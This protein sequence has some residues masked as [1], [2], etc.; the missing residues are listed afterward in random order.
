MR[1]TGFLTAAA[2]LVTGV[3]ALPG[4]AVAVPTGQGLVASVAPSK[5][6]KKQFSGISQSTVIS[7]TFDNYTTSQSPRTTTFTIPKDVKFTNGNIPTCPLSAIQ[8]KFDAQARASCPQSITGQGSVEVNGGPAAGGIGGLVTFFSGGPNVI[9]VQS[10]IGP[11][12]TT[13]TII[14]NIQGR[15]L[16]FSNIPNTPG[17]VLTKFDTTFNKRKVGKRKMKVNGKKKTVPIYYVMGR[18]STGTLA[19]SETTNFYSGE[20]LSASASQKCKQ[21]KSKKK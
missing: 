21:K 3:L 19:T 20:T 2:L 4:T 8:G 6:D 13:L 14:G 1:R 17:L 10:D 11:G 5:L 9:Y 18:C 16:V 12:A 15:S 7:T